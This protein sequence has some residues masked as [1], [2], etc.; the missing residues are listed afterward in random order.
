MFL[1]CSISETVISDC[2]VKKK[3]GLP[4]AR[5]RIEITSEMCIRSPVFFTHELHKYTCCTYTFGNYIHIYTYIHIYFIYIS[6]YIYICI[7]R[8][9][10]IYTSIYVFEYIYIYL[11]STNIYWRSYIDYICIYIY[12]YIYTFLNEYDTAFV[13][14]FRLY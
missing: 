11:F 4:N 7:C 13:R 8:Y 6:T 14:W 10:C 9:V 3:Q 5:F 12:I 1:N 2:Y